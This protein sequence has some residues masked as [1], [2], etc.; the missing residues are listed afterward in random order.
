MKPVN[1]Q[2]GMVAGCLWTLTGCVSPITVAIN[3]YDGV[4]ERIEIGDSQDAVIA[5]LEPTQAGLPGQARKRPDRFVENGQ[6]VFIYYARTGR[7][8]DGLTTDDEFTPYVFR[9]RKLVAIG[10]TTLDGP[11]TQGQARSQT[12]VHVEPIIGY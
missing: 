7:Q 1:W 9:D 6:T 11:K 12:T 10:W 4:A 5:L 8:P 3:Q 2:A